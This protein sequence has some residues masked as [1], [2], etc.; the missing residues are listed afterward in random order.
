VIS[1]TLGPSLLGRSPFDV[2]VIVAEWRSRINGHQ[3]A[4]AAVELALW[5]LQGKALMRPL[6]DLIGGRTRMTVPETYPFDRTERPEEAFGRARALRAAGVGVFKVYLSVGDPPVLDPEREAIVAA[7]REGAG[8]DVEIRVDANGGWPDA[9]TAVFAIRRLE[10]WGIS[11]IEEPVRVGDLASCREIRARISTPLCLD[12][13]VLE[14]ADALVAIRA[15]AC[16]VINVKLMKTGGIL[17]ALKLNA[18]AEAAGVATHVGNMGHSTIGVA[19]ILHL[20]AA[21]SNAMTSDIDP[22]IRGGD[23]ALDIA[24]GLV[25][26]VDRGLCVWAPPSGP[27]LGVVLLEDA[28]RGQLELAG[29]EI[30][31]SVAD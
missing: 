9:S 4:R 14:P 16:D 29:D 31:Q 27:G 24:S 21:L 15:D 11:M 5:D 10:T 3:A 30:G 8:P 23:I 6:H 7:V 28:I 22:P 2:E 26:S 19:A 18:V 13:S 12:E 17:G 1:K 25:G 20:H